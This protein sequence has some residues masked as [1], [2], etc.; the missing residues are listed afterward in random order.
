MRERRQSQAGNAPAATRCADSRCAAILP[1]SKMS[2]GRPLACPH[3]GLLF[4]AK[5]HWAWLRM[6]QQ[7]TALA[8]TTRQRLEPLAGRRR[9]V[10]LDD[11]RSAWNVGSIV[12]TVDGAGWDGVY[13]CG[14]SATPPNKQLAKAALGAEE[15]V[16]WTYRAAVLDAIRELQQAGLAIV[17]LEQTAASLPL[18]ALASPLALILGHEIGG[19]SQQALAQCSSAFH[20]PMRGQKISLNVAVAFGVAAYTM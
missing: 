7:E 18:K 4:N 10:V 13:I 17:A 9:I 5:P 6:S 11:I 12:R 14:I 16:L 8:A 1:F 2:V 19:V 3:C 15:T 20:L